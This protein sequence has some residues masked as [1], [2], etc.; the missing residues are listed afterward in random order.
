[1][2]LQSIIITNL[3]GCAILIILL[4]SSYFVRQRKQIEDKLFTILILLTMSACI[5]EMLSYIID[6]KSFVGVRILALVL[7]TWLFLTN[8]GVSFMWCIYTDLM[9]YHSTLRIKRRYSKIGTP[10]ILFVIMLILN[11]PFG[12]V[13]SIDDKNVYHRE[14]IGYFYYIPTFLYLAYSA[15]IRRR[16]YRRHNGSEF[17]PIWMFLAPVFIGATG[18]LLV[19]GISVA[20]C[21][22]SLGLVG[23]YMCLQ[24]ELS[25]LDPLTKLYNRNFLDQ[26]LEELLARGSSLGGMMIDVDSFKSINDRFG[27]SIGDNALIDTANIIRSC[28]TDKAMAIRFAGDEFIIIVPDSDIEKLHKIETN[29]RK[30]LERFNCSSDR[31]YKL[32]L[33]I[34][35]ASAA[36]GTV[37]TDE[38]LNRID[39]LMYEEKKTKHTRVDL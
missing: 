18:Q 10:L 12:F 5:V 39:E 23:I 19:Y 1:M 36:S 22:V 15:V 4:I 13:F 35:C 38:F 17:Y 33:S 7:N 11:V 24:N 2:N 20:W 25:Y 3:M 26:K 29:I 30:A 16:Y 14:L 32:S 6:G 34:G 28:L 8:L 37:T 9:L 27:H 21:S 31:P